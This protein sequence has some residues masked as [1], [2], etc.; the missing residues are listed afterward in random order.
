MERQSVDA[1][2]IAQSAREKQRQHREALAEER[3][4][5]TRSFAA[6]IR[7]AWRQIEPR[8][9]VW[10]WHMDA[11]VEH[12]EA[13]TAGE[14]KRLLINV[15]PG[16]SK[17]LTV[18]VFWP[19]WEWICD[20]HKRTAD[21]PT[22]FRPD[23]KY[24]FG[25]Y[26]D[27]LARDKALKCLQLVETSWYQTLFRERW[28]PDSMQW[29]ASKFANRQ[30]GW[31]LATSVGG[32]GTGQHADRKIVDDPTKPQEALSG[33]MSATK[34]ALENTWT[35]WSQTMALRNTSADT[36][37]VIIMQRLHERDLAG[38]LLAEGGYEAL[39]IPMHYE[40]HH[41]LAKPTV[42]KRDAH[43][44]PVRTWKDPRT[45]E[46]ELMCPA[47]FSEA[48]CA[49]RKRDLGDTGYAAQEQ[50]RPTPAG[51]R[52]YKR[53]DF[54]H[55]RVVPSE[56]TWAI[57]GDCTFKEI[58]SSDWVVLQVWIAS[59]PNFYL[60]DQVRDRLDVLQTCDAIASL[61]AKWARVREILIEDAA[62]GPAVVQIMRRTLPG[63]KLVTP[64]GG[65][66][67]RANASAA[68]HRSGNVLL[69]PAD[70]CPW[71]H[72]YIEEHTSFPFGAHDD[73]VDAQSQAINHLAGDMLDYEKMVATMRQLGIA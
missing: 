31:R 15:P 28:Q 71:V 42:L 8:P 44:Q 59:A 11:M 14:L 25:T 63:L 60:I 17:T 58:D 4:R 2:P 48:D 26:G 54:G 16:S 51:G 13:V 29:G 23:I 27:A 66:A 10:G 69:P 55:W 36:A 12:L 45:R 7:A 35:W 33:T 40:P 39:C 43:G 65:K 52:L 67:A 46:G 73:Q 61:R 57:S 49:Q 53:S 70:R 5:C 21:F 34:I 24:I 1:A 72:D 41:P 20:Q 56:G 47:R 32:Q 22:G 64:L 19:A 37:N 3:E 50:Q 68:Y 6:F 30:G 38:R 18:Q 9:V 62:N